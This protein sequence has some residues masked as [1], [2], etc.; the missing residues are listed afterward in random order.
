MPLGKRL[1]KSRFVQW[2]LPH[3]IGLYIRFVRATSR[4]TEEG[5]GL[6]EMLGRWHARQPF[7]LC[8]WHGR[9]MMMA[10]MRSRNLR[11]IHVLIST[12]SDGELIARSIEGL[13]F[14][15]VRGSS[16][17]GGYAAMRGLVELIGKGDSAAFTPDGPIGPRMRVQGGAISAASMGAIPIYPIAVSTRRGPMLDSWD[18]FL[19]ATPF[20]RG[21][22]IVGE[23]ID[24][25]PDLDDEQF[26]TYRVAL[27]RALNT[28]TAEADRRMGRDLVEP[29]P[30]RRRRT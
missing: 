28:L 30:A 22:Y 18:R 20:N 10:R 21:L 9:L 12:H 23:R 19:L 1:A 8:F 3:L 4:F 16:K 13:G 17:R 2:L 27:E 29:A 25:P 7:V 6:A 5:P 15:T 24:V 14:S 11:M 26:E